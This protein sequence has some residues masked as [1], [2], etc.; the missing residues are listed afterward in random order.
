MDRAYKRIIQISDIHLMADVNG[1]LLGV[2]TQESF[3]AIIDLLKQDTHPIDVI[4]LSGDLSQDGSEAAYKRIKELLKPFNVPIYYACG[5]HD[6]G[7]IMA[8]VFSCPVVSCEK[9]VIIGDW[10]M[11]ILN[12]QKLG[13]TYGYLEASQFEF[14]K[15]CLEE[16][17]ALHPL[18][19]FHHQPMPVGS[20]WLDGVGLTNAAEFW[21]FMQNYP[22]V[23]YL[24]FGHVHQE[25]EGEMQGV[26][27]YALPSTCIQFHTKQDDFGLQEL[28]PGYRWVNL[29]NDGHLETAVVR[30][31]KYVGVFDTNAKGY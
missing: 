5:N 2:K 11:I 10:Q 7:K 6:D 19:V 28:P 27:C 22:Q 9:R 24:L 17:P 23:K 21:K 25:F 12:S 20:K 1:E 3:Q 30:A 13:S 16:S 26:K 15:N 4:L 31:A 14:L 18:I 8:K 29:Y